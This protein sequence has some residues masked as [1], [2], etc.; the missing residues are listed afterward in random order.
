MEGAGKLTR[1][2]F[3][4]EYR[5]RGCL[6][7]GVVTAAVVDTCVPLG[8]FFLETGVSLNCSARHAGI[9]GG[10]NGAINCADV[11]LVNEARCVLRLS[12]IAAQICRKQN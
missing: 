2:V 1:L 7:Y 10:V 8:G 11:A 9:K 5:S 6:I 4:K 12:E 3:S